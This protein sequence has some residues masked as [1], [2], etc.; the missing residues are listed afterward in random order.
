LLNKLAVILMKDMYLYS[1]T[2]GML[3]I[4]TCMN[5]IVMFFAHCS[6]QTT[7]SYKSYA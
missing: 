6:I 3:H 2:L 4:I 1:L 5:S 7:G